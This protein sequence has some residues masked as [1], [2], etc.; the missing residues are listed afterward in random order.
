[1][2]C[3]SLLGSIIGGER[4]IDPLLGQL[5][6]ER[7]KMP[8]AKSTTFRQEK[9]IRELVAQGERSPVRVRRE[10]EEEKLLGENQISVKTI[11]RR[12]QEFAGKDESGPWSLADAD[13]DPDEVCL[14]L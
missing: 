4:T 12:I 13:V 14:I 3:I 1:M 10:L 8:R 9:I 11:A 6:P 7:D 2:R 5:I